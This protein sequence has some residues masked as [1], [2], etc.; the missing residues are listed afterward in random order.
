MTTIRRAALAGAAVTLG[1]VA[2]TGCSSSSD[3]AAS[4]AAPA[5]EA[6]ASDGA[7]PMMSPV[8]PPVIIDKTAMSATAKV[9]DTL[10]INVDKLAGTTIDVD[11]PDLIEVSQA[12]ESGGAQFN[13]GGKVLKPG[14]AVITVTNP[15]NTTRT[16]TVTIT[17]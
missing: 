12:H 17:E 6:A 2:L 1:L 7:S 3:S 15:D 14:T 10:Y 8:L 13:P 4:S 11:K 9:G 5:S 16:I